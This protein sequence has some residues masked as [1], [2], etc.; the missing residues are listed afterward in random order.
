MTFLIVAFDV[1]P[2]QE[3]EAHN[4]P[5]RNLKNVAAVGNRG[6]K[7]GAVRNNAVPM[8]H[9]SSVFDTQRLRNLVAARRN[10]ENSGVTDRE[11]RIQR[12]LQRRGIVRDTVTN[13]PELSG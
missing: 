7:P 12:F 11:Y 13:D 9:M 4:R 6:D 10:D 1:Y 3:E 2:L 8:S 5:A